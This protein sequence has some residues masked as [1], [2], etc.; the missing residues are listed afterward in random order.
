MILEKKPLVF[1]S[2]ECAFLLPRAWLCCNAKHIFRIQLR[3]H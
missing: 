1:K 2:P 3:Q